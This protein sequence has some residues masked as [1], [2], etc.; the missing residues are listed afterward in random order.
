MAAYGIGIIG[1]GTVGGGVLD[2]LASD[3]PLLRTR[4]R[5]ELQVRAIVTRDPARPR[6]QPHF[7]A[8]LGSDIALITEDPEI[9]CVLHLVGGTD[10]ARTLALAVL[11][12]GKHLVTANKALLALHGQEIF[13]TAA[14]HGVSVA[15]EAAVA[16]GIPLI[17]ALRAGLV[18]NRIKAIHAILNGTS[19]YILTRMEEGSCSYAEALAAAQALGY[20]EADPTLDVDGT[21]AAHKLAILAR[22]AF[23][24]PIDFAR[25]SVEGIQALGPE[26]FISA[27]R[28]G[29]RIKLLASAVAR[30]RGLELRV[31]PTLLPIDSPLA[32]VQRNYN[33]VLVE[34]HA[35][36]PTLLVGQ[37]AG[38]L[39][40]ASAVLADLVDVATG[41]YAAMAHQFTFFTNDEPTTIL[42][43]AD[44]VTSSYARFHVKDEVGVLARITG[45][46]SQCGI[47][48]ASI[49]QDDDGQPG[50][51][52]LE[53]ITHPCR[54]GDFFRA[55]RILDADASCLKP[56]TILRRLS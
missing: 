41:G 4:T 45:T 42:D 19:N 5:L 51:V 2:L 22:I 43:E 38:A 25:V 28:L 55:I 56:A 47:S 15:F 50:M 21:D 31:A 23:G 27:R 16:G 53:A 49:H 7:G 29:C 33:G 44:E 10:E 54:A 24:G 35:A 48:I 30:E 17:G 12:A 37:G 20:A 39:P 34:A 40:T 1:W 36:G 13:R 32:G 52:T 6:P 14:E 26:D 18:A 8:R 11:R 46:L 9:R 3:G